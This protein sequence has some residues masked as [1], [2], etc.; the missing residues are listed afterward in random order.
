[1]FPNPYD[2]IKQCK[3]LVLCSKFEGMPLVILETLT[4]GKPVISF[5]CKSG[6]SELI[7]DKENGLL[8]KDQDFYEL[9]KKY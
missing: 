8:V 9:E 1:M 2:Y 7:T 4:L 6:P 5:N 3:F